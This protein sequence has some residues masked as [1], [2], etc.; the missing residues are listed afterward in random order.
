M[1]YIITSF[2]IGAVLGFLGS[3]FVWK[4]NKKKW[5][6]VEA[7]LNF[8]KDYFATSS[9]IAQEFANEKSSQVKTKSFTDGLK[10][11]KQ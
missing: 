3:W 6:A 8:T 10:K 9:K 11:K 1:L 4:N 5:E 7:R 2:V